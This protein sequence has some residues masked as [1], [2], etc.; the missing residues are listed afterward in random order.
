M[1]TTKQII[2]IILLLMFG[3]LAV[4]NILYLFD[5]VSEK[6]TQICFL[7]GLSV[8]FLVSLLGFIL[9][10]TQKSETYP[11]NIMTPAKELGFLYTATATIW[12]VTYF[13]AVI[14]K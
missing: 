8:V 14:F 9:K 11:V 5:K 1:K 13:I 4:F 3:I 7:I 10:K 12:L 2:S 6:S